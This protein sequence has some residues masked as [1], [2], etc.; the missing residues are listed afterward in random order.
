M[1]NTRV[2]LSG[3]GNSGKDISTIL[4]TIHCE[5]GIGMEELQKLQ[6]ARKNILREIDKTTT[7]LVQIVES[8]KPLKFPEEL[9]G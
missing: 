6:N 8:I 9:T 3:R 5:D 4:D 7:Q 2:V 1:E